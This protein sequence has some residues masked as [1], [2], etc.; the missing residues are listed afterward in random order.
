MSY[1]ELTEDDFDAQFLPVENLEQGH[2]V[3][4]FDAYDSKDRDFLQFMAANYPTHVWTRIEGADGCLYNINGWHIVN[5]I[6]YV[7]TEVP[8]L[9]KNEYQALDYKPHE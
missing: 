7:I 2:G 9:E 8:W 4:Q 1:I 3:Y 5:R 6:D